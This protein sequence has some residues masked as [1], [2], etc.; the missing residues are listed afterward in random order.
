MKKW[1]FAATIAATLG[2]AA[3]AAAQGQHLQE[4]KKSV[5]SF[6]QPPLTPRQKA[7]YHKTGMLAHA[8]TKAMQA[9]DYAEAEA[10]ARASLASGPDAGF[11]EETLAAALDAQGKSQEALQAYKEIAN[12]GGN[13]PRNLLPYALLSLRA[14]N[15]P[16][17]VLA[18]N[19]AL[20]LLDDGDM[21]R[22]NSHFSVS[23]PQS[24]ALLAA[25]HTALGLQ[26]DWRG[27]HGAY[28]GYLEQSLLHFQQAAAL[29]PGSPLTNYYVGYGLKRLGRR[30]EAQKA[31][32][33]AAALD[34]GDIKAAALKELPVSM[35]PR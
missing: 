31:F 12:E 29:E 8:A 3:A 17:A 16:Q 5:S 26:A 24:R 28:Q 4:R 1:I 9:G 19:K 14:G 18:Y 2:T 21:V 7:A 20:P 33:K 10:D 34:H 6:N 11:A 22:R 30:A 27:Y 15:W 25:L 23:V 13:D 35:Q 32:Q